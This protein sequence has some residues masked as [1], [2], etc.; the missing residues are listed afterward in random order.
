MYWMQVFVLLLIY[1]EQDICELK[2]TH[3]AKTSVS[4]E[5]ITTADNLAETQ[6]AA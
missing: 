5:T 2:A 6:C 1:I 4:S 3:R